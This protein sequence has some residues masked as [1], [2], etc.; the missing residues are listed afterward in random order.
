M[1]VGKIGKLQR[2]GHL[3]DE[4]NYLKEIKSTHCSLKIAKIG[5]LPMQRIAYTVSESVAYS[6][7]QGGGK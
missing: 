3:G 2:I 6:H 4:A 5:G 1:L 7:V